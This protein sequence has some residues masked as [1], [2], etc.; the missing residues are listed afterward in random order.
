MKGFLELKRIALRNLGRHKV[1]TFLTCAAIT[2]S[3]AV[4]I[5]IDS[6]LGGMFMESRRNIINYEIGAAKLQTKL[7]FDKHDEMPSYEN[8]ANWELYAAILDAAGYNVA[9]RYTFSGTIYSTSGTAP[10]VI[11]AVDPSAEA[12]TLA[13]TRYVELGRYIQD[14]EFGIA[15]GAQTAEKLKVG[16]PMR[17]TIQELDDLIA[18]AALTSADEAFIRSC[19]QRIEAK[20]QIGETKEYAEEQSKNRMSLKPD[21]PKTDADKLWTLI[22]ATGANDVRIAT[23]IDYKLAPEQISKDKWNGELWSLLTPAEQELLDAVYEFDEPTSSY[24]LAEQ[25]ETKQHEALQAMIRVD[26]SGALRHVNQ[27]IDAKVVGMVNSPDPVNNFNIAYIPLDVLQD[28]AGMMLEGHVTELL[29]RD[30]TLGAADMTS[31]I[32]SANTIRAALNT[33]LAA[34]GTLLP[35]ELDVRFWMDYVSDYLSYEG[36]ENGASQIVSILLFF[37]ALISISNTIL[38]AIMERTKETGMMRALGMTEAQLIFVY[39][40]EA[41]ALGLIGSVLGII[42]GCILNIPMVNTGIDFSRMMEQLGG[43]M[44][45]RVAGNFRGMWRPATIVGSGIAA[46]ILSSLMAI[47]PTHRATKMA[48]TESLRFE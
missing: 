34:Q 13:Y 33:G 10:L 26:F 22:D 6:W 12:K 5:W 24:L 30:K 40:M 4:Y 25:D 8:F 17:P 20:A 29:I 43:S 36:L 35:E 23:V 3:V 7:Y 48:I 38:L 9:P 45:Y 14:G 42:L 46:T 11:N 15:L 18:R 1:K 16:I 37:L 32:E 39:M 31:K 27:V 21:I 2:I 19:Y 47:L 44:G 28:E 41:G